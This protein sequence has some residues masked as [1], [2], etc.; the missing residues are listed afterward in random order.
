[1]AEIFGEER[2]RKVQLQMEY[3]LQPPFPGGSPAS[4]SGELVAAV[5]QDAAKFQSERE[6]IAR[7]AAAALA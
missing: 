7:R 4:A 1:M 5:T 6:Q 3:D 2:A